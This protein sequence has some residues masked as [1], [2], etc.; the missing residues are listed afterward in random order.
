MMI[1]EKLYCLK[2]VK[3]IS[4]FLSIIKEIYNE[5]NTLGKLA[6]RDELVTST[7]HALLK[8]WIYLINH[9]EWHIGYNDFQ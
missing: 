9:K 7:L 5:L 4:A 1:K 8:E 3:P 6:L 2:F